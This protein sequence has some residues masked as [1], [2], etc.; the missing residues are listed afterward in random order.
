M[1][2]PPFCGPEAGLP[3]LHDVFSL[4]IASDLAFMPDFPEPDFGAG[5]SRT[6]PMMIL[7]NPKHCA[8]YE[9]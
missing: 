3:L 2:H 6:G 1:R 4:S 9:E 7:G 8:V 5:I